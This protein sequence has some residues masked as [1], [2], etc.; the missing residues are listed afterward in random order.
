MRVLVTGSR[1]WRNGQL[2]RDELTTAYSDAVAAG[3]NEFVVVHG[4]CKSGADS[5]AESWGR[6]KTKVTA[7]SATP[8][9]VEV[10]PAKWEK[11]CQKT[12]QPGHRRAD[13][14]GW[15]VCPAAGFYRNETMV[16]TGIDRCLAFIQDES[17]GSTHCAHYAEAHGVDTRYFRVGTGSD[18]LF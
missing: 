11:P 13:H 3:D 4:A 12:C 16:N 8:A 15:D 5:Y 14:R 2:I 18:A 10:H 6:W 17:K 1:T 7:G 9:R